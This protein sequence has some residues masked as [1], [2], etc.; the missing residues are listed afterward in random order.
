MFQVGDLGAGADFA[1]FLS[2]SKVSVGGK[3]EYKRGILPAAEPIKF[4]GLSP[5]V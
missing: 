1:P 2:I 5:V 3:A 4:A